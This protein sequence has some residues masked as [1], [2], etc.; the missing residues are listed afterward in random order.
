MQ[1]IPLV[2]NSFFFHW[3]GDASCGG[4]VVENV[5]LVCNL[6][7]CVGLGLLVVRNDALVGIAF[8]LPPQGASRRAEG[9]SGE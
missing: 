6:A 2:C 7:F 1:N 3:L 8:F 5:A 4:L 9:C